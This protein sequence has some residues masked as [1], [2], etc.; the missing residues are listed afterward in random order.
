MDWLKRLPGVGPIVERLMRTH[1]WFAYERLD[2]V[3]WTRLAAA[4]TF[5]SFL[6]LFPLLTVAAAIAA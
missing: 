1:A 6:A 4:M 3:H 5:I 2:Q